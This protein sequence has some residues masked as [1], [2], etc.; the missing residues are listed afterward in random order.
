MRR[1]LLALAVSAA[2][3]SAQAADTVRLYNWAEYLGKTSLADFTAAT[4][5]DATIDFYDSNDVLETKMLTGGSGYDLVFPAMSNAER[6]GRAGALLAIDPGRLKNYGNLDPAI[7]KLL[8]G[9]PGGRALGVPY[10]WGTIGLAYNKAE[11]KK[12]LGTDTI[13]SL[14]SLFDPAIAG[15]LKACGI[16]VI[17]SP[18]EMSAVALNYLGLD[19]YSEK[20]D[21]IAKAGE[22]LKGMVK[23]VRYFHNQKATS[24]LAD[25]SICAAFIYSGDALAAR[26][27]AEEAKNGV[28]LDYVIPKEGTMMWVDLMAIPKDAPRPDLA[29]RFIDFMLEP[30]SMADV[31]D[32]VGFA[33]ANIKSLPLID[34]AFASDP[35]LYPDEATRSRLFL[36]R[37]IE[38]KGL[39]LR[40]RMWTNVKTGQ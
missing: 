26:A 2:A 36:D 33:N 25:G 6:E 21:D 34:P 9:V 13:D 8:D 5:I 16:A 1:L 23:N 27:R 3:F 10:T 24:D 15:K 30:K 35:G 38:G 4:G 11:V 37:S 14:A 19:P 18:L 32:T 17:D 22:L 12:A 31:T 7:L 39:K 20:P 28:E 40:T 29:Y